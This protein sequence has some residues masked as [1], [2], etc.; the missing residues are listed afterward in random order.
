MRLACPDSAPGTHR[1]I[2]DIGKT[3]VKLHLLN[4]ALDA[5]FSQQ[6]TNRVLTTGPYPHFDIEGI[7]QWLI[8]GITKAA[9]DYEISALAI[10]THGATA[11][12]VDRHCAETSSGLTLPVLDYEFAGVTDATPSY[13]G[14]RPQFSETYSPDLPCGLN[15]GRQLYWQQQ[16]FPEEFTQATDILMYPQYWAW[17]LSGELCSEVTSLGCH[18]DLWAV[19]DGHFSS[20]V[21][22]MGWSGL[23]PEVVPAWT[24]IGTILPSIRKLTGLPESCR[25]YAGLHDSNASFTRYVASQ[26]GDS[27]TV[28]STGT[29]SILMSSGAPLESLDPTRDML[30]NVDLTGKP[31]ACARFMGGREF[32]AICARVNT[33]VSSHFDQAT[34]QGL[35]D[36]GAMALPDF[37]GGSGP[38]GGRQSEIVGAVSAGDGAA[39]ASLYCALM[40]DYQLDLLSAKGD[41]FIEGAFLKNP[42]LCSI[43]A[44]LR[45]GQKVWLS[46]D[47]TGTVQGC[48]HLAYWGEREC[49]VELTSSDVTALVGLEQY[50]DDWRARSDTVASGRSDAQQAPCAQ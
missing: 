19:G 18:T 26:P 44:Q 17:R 2:L 50:R 16:Q 1:L 27:F 36:S 32:E 49:R 3:H 38:F 6:I 39:L 24:K 45:A 31:V 12:L 11:A 28:I 25:V 23:F 47:A 21:E 30:A 41:I 46:A 15:L 37:S 34:L 5:V 40:L 48:A 29:W 35:I 33:E 14:V 9:E 13:A 8:S 42:L 7:W 10:T 43:L 4:G 20:L 22:K